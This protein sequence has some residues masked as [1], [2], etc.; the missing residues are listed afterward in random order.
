[1]TDYKLGSGK[2]VGVHRMRKIRGIITINSIT[3]EPDLLLIVKDQDGNLINKIKAGP[4]NPYKNPKYTPAELHKIE[5]C[6]RVLKENNISEMT[7]EEVEYMLTP[8]L[9]RTDDLTPE[10]FQR[11]AGFTVEKIINYI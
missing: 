5:M 6:N 7:E 11:L 1:M 9:N 4:I 2:I 10:E 8:W 3:F